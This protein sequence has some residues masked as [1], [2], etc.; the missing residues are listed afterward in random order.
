MKN[1]KLYRPAVGILIYKKNHGF[2]TGKRLDQF[3][4]AWQMPQGGIDDGET[5]EQAM[6]RE[7]FEETNITSYKII[8]QYNEWLYYDLPQNIAKK[9]WHGKFV[10]QKQKWFLLE[11]TGSD[12]E[13]NIHT[14]HQEFSEWSWHKTHF[15]L[16]NIV[17]FKKDIYQQIFSKW[18]E[19]LIY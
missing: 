10:G 16:N 14:E 3:K 8:A 18:N 7:L 19:S 1:D 11:F 9:F 13:I 5:A 6:S 12:T 4:N 17:E 15:I 2:W